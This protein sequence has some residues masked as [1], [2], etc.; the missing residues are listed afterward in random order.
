[1]KLATSEL[2]NVLIACGLLLVL[3]RCCGALFA[4]LRQP[5]VI[6]EILGGLL[7]GPT[8]LGSL[9]PGLYTGVFRSGGGSALVLDAIQQLGLIALMFCSGATLDLGGVRRDARIIAIVTTAGLTIPF[10]AGVLLA[11]FIDAGRGVGA[12]GSD[13]AFALVCGIAFAV[14]SVPVIS[15]IMRDLGILETRLARTVISS[16]VIEDIALY[17]LLAAAVALVGATGP[18]GP[19]PLPAVTTPLAPWAAMVAKVAIALAFAGGVLLLVPRLTRAIEAHR[20]LSFLRA[21][22]PT[23]MIVLAIAIIVAGLSIG[24]PTMLGALIAGAALRSG[25]SAAGTHTHETISRFAYCSVIPI[26]FA[27][28][29]LRLDLATQFNPIGCATLIAT[30]SAIKFASVYAASRISGEA[31]GFSRQLAIA[32]NARGGPGIV[33]ATV[34]FETGIISEQFF[35]SLVMLAII[36][37]LLAANWLAKSLAAPARRAAALGPSVAGA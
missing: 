23:V 17:V 19:G 24:L 16:A 2:M 3:A 36:T 7:L 37:S 21:S 31:R 15:R 35:T 4:R 8:V 1:M 26:Y 11:P 32:M 22:R 18:G 29:G 34:A 25:I 20:R 14:T 33:L 9:A 5:P 27:S 6:G 30:G 12:A 28:V 13:L 10:A